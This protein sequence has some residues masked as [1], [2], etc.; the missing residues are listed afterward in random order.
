ML[1]YQRVV[2]HVLAIKD[3][4]ISDSYASLP[5]DRTWVRSSEIHLIQSLSRFSVNLALKTSPS[6]I[7]TGSIKKIMAFKHNN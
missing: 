4:V 3:V 6:K 1:L 7:G 2:Y 5:E